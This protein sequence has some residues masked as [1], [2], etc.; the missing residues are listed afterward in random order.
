MMA[1]NPRRL[2]A[3]LSCAVAVSA[4]GLAL[5]QR[6]PVLSE[7]A[8]AMV[9]TWEFSNSDRDKI[10]TLTLKAD[11]TMLG[12]K[13]EFDRDC[14]AIF[15][16][17]RDIVAWRFN[18]N[19]LLRLLD[20]KGKPLVEFSEVEN[21]IYEAPTAGVGVLFLQNAEAAGPP[22]RNPAEMAGEWSIMR[23]DRAIC[24]LTLANSPAGEE[25]ALRVKPGCDAAVT[26]F[27]PVSW[28]MD[29]GELVLSSARGEGWRFEQD[30]PASWRRVPE[31]A[32]PIALVRR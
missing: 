5:G 11:A 13:L 6:P 21:G 15:P 27:G 9:G 30:E 29:R 8:K 12:L 28:R 10:C 25:L 22:A 16:F 31:G 2:L 14:A 17:V 18:E 26:R 20:A 3:V 1:A 4:S 19:E 24:E 23:G 32:D 7:S